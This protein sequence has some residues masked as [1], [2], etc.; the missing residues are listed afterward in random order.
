MTAREKDNEIVPLSAGNAAEKEGCGGSAQVSY[1]SRLRSAA[2]PRDAS[3]SAGVKGD[4]FSVLVKR[5]SIEIR[6]RTIDMRRDVRD[7][8]YRNR[9]TIH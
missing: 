3:S 1:D 9:T 6:A 4:G 8:P 2:K 5:C 7:V